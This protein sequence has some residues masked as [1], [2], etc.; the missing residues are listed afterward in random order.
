MYTPQTFLHT[1]IFGD[2]LSSVRPLQYRKSDWQD[3]NRG[4]E[5]SVRLILK[6]LLGVPS[7]HLGEQE[8][9]MWCF[10]FPQENGLLVVHLHRGTVAELSASD[11]Q[12]KE[13]LEA[14]D[15]LIEEVTTR[16]KLL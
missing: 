5:R 9:A 8:H 7:A 2:Y 16:L 6:A 13:I 10:Q 3:L 4:R 14:V 15:Y 1:K 12:Q 11:E